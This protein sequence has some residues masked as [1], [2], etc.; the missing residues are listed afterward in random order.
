MTIPTPAIPSVQMVALK[1]L[2]LQIPDLQ[3]GRSLLTPTESWAGD[4]FATVSMIPSI[5]DSYVP[6][7]DEKVQ[8]DVWGRP[9]PNQQYRGVPKERCNAIVN[10]L[11]YL[12]QHSTPLVIDFPSSNYASVDLSYLEPEEKSLA[13]AE[14]PGVSA[15]VG[16]AT[17]ALS[18][19]RLTVCFVYK[20]LI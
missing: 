11:E 17:V 20:V 14:K 6:V 19:A 10:H 2:G 16:S 1:W 4:I 13:V 5:P 7:H 3:A 15:Q 8:I 12:A 18:R 9:S